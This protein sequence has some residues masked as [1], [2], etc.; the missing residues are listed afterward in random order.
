M[1]GPSI[2]GNNDPLPQFHLRQPQPMMSA[3]KDSAL[4]QL[5]DV[6]VERL[7]FGICWARGGLWR[8]REVAKR[9]R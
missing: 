3:P 4:W 5:S 1:A 2:Q 8:G 9:G 6:L 7:V